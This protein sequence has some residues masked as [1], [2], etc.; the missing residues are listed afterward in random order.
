MYTLP[1]GWGGLG[2]GANRAKGR[3]M[4][5]IGTIGPVAAGPTLSNCPRASARGIA[6]TEQMGSIWRQE[7]E[8]GVRAFHLN[9]PQVL[10]FTCLRDGE[11]DATGSC[12]RDRGAGLP[13]DDGGWRR[14]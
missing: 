8:G 7:P 12:G 14:R 9:A 13:P 5:E 11:V 2:R 4:G 6:S 10:G 3:Y 1:P